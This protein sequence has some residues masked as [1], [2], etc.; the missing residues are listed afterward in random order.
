VTEKGDLV[1]VEARFDVRGTSAVNRYVFDLGKG[2]AQVSYY[3]KSSGEEKWDYQYEQKGGIW[4]PKSVSW[5]RSYRQDGMEMRLKR[6][7]S[8]T[9]NRVNEPVDREA[10]SLVKLGL[11]PNDWIRDRVSDLSFRYMETGR[12]MADLDKLLTS[13]PASAFSPGDSASG[14]GGPAGGSTADGRARAPAGAATRMREGPVWGG[15]SSAGAVLAGIPGWVWAMAIMVG[16]AVV[17]LAVIR[18][19]WRRIRKQSGPS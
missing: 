14:S 9:V 1:T 18:I 16:S 15:L 10:F 7:V 19:R 11:K 8:F 2:G 17:L 12:E 4:V 5:A 3:A 13:L 6:E